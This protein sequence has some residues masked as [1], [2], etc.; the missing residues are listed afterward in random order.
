MRPFNSEG[1]LTRMLLALS[2]GLIAQTACVRASTIPCLGDCDGDEQVTVDEV[3][4]G[5]HIALGTAPVESCAAF[6]LAGDGAVTVDELLKGVNKALSG[7]FETVALPNLPAGV[8]VVYDSIGIPH[9]YGSDLNSVLYVQG[10]VQAAHRF[11]QMDMARR[12]AEGRLSELFGAVTLKQDVTMRTIFTSRDG[13]RLEEVGWESLQATDPEIAGFGS[14]YAD[15]VNAWLG[16]LRAGRNG[17]TLPP[18]YTFIV[19]NQGPEDLAPWR[20]QDT[21]A[22]GIGGAWGSDS[23][24]LADTMLDQQGWETLEENVRKDVLRTTP[25]SPVPVLPGAAAMTVAGDGAIT[26]VPPAQPAPGVA[27]AV[28]DLLAEIEGTAPVGGRGADRGS[29]NWVVGPGLSETGVAMLAA[30]PHLSLSN[31]SAWFLLQI[32]VTGDATHGISRQ[33]SGVAPPGA[34]G[35]QKGFNDSGAWGGTNSYFDA[36]DVYVETLT[37]PPDYPASPRTVL[38][39]GEQVPVLRIEEPFLLK[40]G[41]VVTYPIEVVPHHGPMVPDPDPDSGEEGLAAT[42]MTL[43]WTGYEPNSES[44]SHFDVIFAENAGDFLA[45][46]H[47]RQQGGNTCWADVHGD[48][49][50]SA[51]THLPQRPPGTVPSL[52]MP[53]TG[54]AEWLTD[55]QG[56]VVWLPEEEFPQALNPPQG[57]IATANSDPLGHTFDNDPFNDGAY[58][59]YWY[60]YGLREQRIQDLL[61]N[62]ANV[63]PPGAKI[64]MADMSAYQY[65]NASLLACRMLP[66]LFQAAEARPDLVSAAMA[67]AI[68]RLRAWTEE[69]PG[70]PACD[71]VTGIDAHDLRADVPPR[72]QPVSDEEKADA[73]A[74]SLFHAWGKRLFL[75]LPSETAVAGLGVFPR[76]VLH[77]LEDIDAT[78]PAFRVYTKGPNGDSILWDDPATPEIET[79]TEAQ[80]TALSAALELLEQEFGSADMS[81]W[82]WGKLHQVRFKHAMSAGGISGYNLGPFPASGSW[83]TVN[84]AGLWNIF[85]PDNFTFSAGPSKRLVVLLD[86]AGIRA[87]NVLAGGENG[88]P[89]ALSTYNRINPATHYGDLIPKWINGQTVEMRIT[90]QSVAADNRRHIKYVPAEG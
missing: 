46:M 80:L 14:A 33:I 59:A 57:F 7:C 23:G 11:W 27:R 15:G 4:K 85:A 66:F 62:R 90:R 87:V 52:P 61:S 54:E 25:L 2:I 75:G 40:G 31:P 21:A 45:A 3:L 88:N 50:Y 77:L 39:N 17:A 12:S 44:R 70:S 8:E 68:A 9:I 65:D 73:A 42:G 79:R 53:G 18:E 29:N 63:R 10:Y 72:A 71:T 58:F 84:S 56:N 30:D 38:F 48:I 86:P 89:G 60:A 36:V 37:T 35:I 67:E 41:D 81:T 28:G 82:L 24:A 43:R 22:I 13:R 51:Y 64:S 47:D 20:P 34:P 78:D 83:D 6:D 19:I 69:K 1:S 16:D 76:L 5:I 55:G 32:D 26:P 49:A 74:S